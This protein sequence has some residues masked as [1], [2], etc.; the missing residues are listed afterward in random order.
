M[1]RGSAPRTFREALA[2]TLHCMRFEQ[3]AVRPWSPRS[4]RSDLFPDVHHDVR[5]LGSMPGVGRDQQLD[6]GSNR[7]GPRERVS[8]V[9]VEMDLLGARLGID[10]HAFDVTLWAKVER[11]DLST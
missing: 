6:A 11:G 4:G 3:D 7:H 2:D 10:G 8:I 9:L 5:G 1:A